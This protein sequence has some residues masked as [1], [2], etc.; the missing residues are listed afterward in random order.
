M[1]IP[2]VTQQM[3]PRAKCRAVKHERNNLHDRYAIAAL[4][5]HPGFLGKQ[6]LPKKVSGFINFNGEGVTAKIVTSIAFSIDQKIVS[7]YIAGFIPG[8]AQYAFRDF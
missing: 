3:D 6:H 7:I 8:A 5:Q 1:R 4:K 2:Q